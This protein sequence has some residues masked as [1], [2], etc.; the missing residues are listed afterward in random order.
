[1]T[2]EERREQILDVTHRI[3]DAEGFPAATPA[4]IAAEAGVHRTLLYQQFGDLPGVFVALIERERRRAGAMFAAAVAESEGEGPERLSSVLAGIVRSLDAAPATWRLFLVP[5]EGAPPE[6]HDQLRAAQDVVRDYLV[7]SLH[8]LGSEV[9]ADP[10]LSARALQAS[11]RELLQYRL[12]APDEL[13]ADRLL[14]F[15]RRL[16]YL[17]GVAPD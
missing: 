1:M 12:T 7:R 9:V 13:S 8:R 17:A 10:E 16:T 11:G 3:V 14:G 2:A 6:Y 5:P 4:R 15:T